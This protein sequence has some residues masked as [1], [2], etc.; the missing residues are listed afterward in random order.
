VRLEYWTEQMEKQT[1]A[2]LQILLDDPMLA[3]AWQHFGGGIFRRSS[4]FHGLAKFLTEQEVRGS[5][6]F[7][8][9]TWN[10]LTAA[11]LS[12][13]FDEVVTV[14]IAHNDQKHEILSFL[15]IT[16]VRC[17]DILDNTEKAKVA[18]SLDFDFAYLDGDHAHDTELDFEMTKKAGRVLFHEVWPSQPPVWEWVH[19]LPHQE[20]KYGGAGLALWT[21][22]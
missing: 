13:F 10:G 17:I 2:R 4:I 21:A 22:A 8:I 16:N 6:C 12:K 11:V 14:D 3:K 19:S 7:E 1:G 20:V 15:G 9:G 5:R 18:A